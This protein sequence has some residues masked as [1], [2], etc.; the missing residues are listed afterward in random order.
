MPDADVC[1]L[2]GDVDRRP[3]GR[4]RVGTQRDRVAHARGLRRGNHEFYGGHLGRRLA[5]GRAASEASLQSSKHGVHLLENNDVVLDGVRFLGATLWTDFLLEGQGMQQ[6]L[7][8]AAAGS[9]A[10]LPVHLENDGRLLT[11]DDTRGRCWSSVI[12]LEKALSLPV[13]G[14]TVVVTHTAPSSRSIAWRY[15]GSA[16]NGAFVNELDY[17][18]E[19]DF[20]PDFGS[21]ATSQS[22]DYRVGGTRVV[23]NPLGYMRRPDEQEE[24][25]RCVQ[26]GGDLR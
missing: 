10:R 17:M 21:T 2:A 18:F 24:W 6:L 23:C 4:R 12:W 19:G 9:D 1:V 8:D 15:E 7:Y 5:E 13:A 20:A 25:F 3:G 11:P 16:L 26:G 14:P 22:F